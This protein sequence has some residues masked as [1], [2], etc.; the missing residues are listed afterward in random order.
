MQLSKM[1]AL[2]TDQGYNIYFILEVDC[3]GPVKK[4]LTLSNS[5]VGI[6]QI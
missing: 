5:S 4:V 6:Y 3:P 2:A 1:S